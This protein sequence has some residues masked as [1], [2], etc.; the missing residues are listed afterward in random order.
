MLPKSRMGRQMLTKM[1]VYPGADHP[2]AG[3]NAVELKV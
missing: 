2:H 3:V 1:K